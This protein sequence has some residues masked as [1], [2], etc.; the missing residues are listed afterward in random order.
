MSSPDPRAEALQLLSRFLVSECSLGDTLQRIAE[1]A[2]EALPSAQMAGISMLDEAGKVTT[3]IFTDRAAPEIDSAQYATGRG[4]CL[5]AWRS[6][7]PVRIDDMAEA[8]DGVYAE[9]A[10]AA[11]AHSVQSTLSLPLA[12]G[13]VG[14][15][16]LN[17]YAHVAQGFSV[18]DEAMGADIATA[19]AVV[20]VNASAYWVTYEL[21]VNLETALRSRA[22]I[23]Q[24]K[25]MLM[26]QSPTLDA[27]GAFEHLR[28]ASQREN[29]KV[30]DIASRIVNREQPPAPPAADDR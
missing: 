28:A 15:G 13:D 3:G 29:V 25:G 2:I 26:A 18:E 16:A 14:V 8:A 17:M 27:D 6:R 21:G 7:K 20:M 22:E 12:V 23:E 19:A 10:A 11:L 24:A 1:I 30:R 5:E 9:F 4:P